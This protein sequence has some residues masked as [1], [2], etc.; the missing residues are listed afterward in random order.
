MF[1]PKQRKRLIS[2][3]HDSRLK[4]NLALTGGGTKIIG[5]LLS[6]PGGSN[7]VSEAI[8]PYSTE[9]LSEFIG[10]KPES[11]CS[12][13]TAKMMAASGFMRP[14]FR[15]LAANASNGE[16]AKPDT[17][18]SLLTSISCTAA[19]A[20][21][22]PKKGIHRCFIASQQHN[23]TRLLSAVLQKGIRSREEEETLVSDLILC[24]IARHAGIEVPDFKLLEEQFQ[25]DQ[26][27]FDEVQAP[28]EL[29]E[30]FAGTRMKCLAKNNFIPDA[31]LADSER[32]TFKGI[33]L[34][35][36]SFNPL[37]DGH[38]EMARVAEQ[39]LG[40]ATQFELA[41]RNADKPPL[42]YLSIR[43]RAQ[44]FP[45]QSLWL[46]N[47]ATFNEKADLFPGAFFLVGIDTI[48]RIAEPKYY[49]G[50]N[51]V[52]HALDAIAANR[53][54]FLVFGRLRSG[55]FQT[56]NDMNLPKKLID[57]CQEVTE[58]Q[59]RNDSSSTAIRKKLE[60]QNP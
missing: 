4:L 47:A 14:S 3:I 18:N 53:C 52:D 29:A 16:M 12:A 45:D 6:V 30:V 19:L 56:L 42:D 39:I 28:I 1:A 8:V 17:T 10:L 26:F 24:E 31:A 27:Q 44:Q 43:D 5:E 51:G 40:N 36:G 11:F 38:R 54:K 50:P 59:Y 57:L 9:S 48:V 55:K 49:E 21:N 32:T 41:I 46:T 7:T 22:R 33:G 58:A 20:T 25:E 60:E 23:Q 34:L 37:H 35:P 15:Q 2:E 13:A